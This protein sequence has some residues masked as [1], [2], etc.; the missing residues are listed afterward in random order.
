[1]TFFLSDQPTYRP[2][3]TATPAPAEPA[4]FFDVVGAGFTAEAI[5]TDRFGRRS[6]TKSELVSEMEAALP[7]AFVAR[8]REAEAARRSPGPR[9]P[10]RNFGPGVN[11]VERLLSDVAAAAIEV[12]ERFSKVPQTI[13]QFEA[14]ISR[15]LKADLDE[16]NATLAMG[17]T[18]AGVAE[19][20]GRGGAGMTDETS[21]A[22]LP[23]GGV[24]G[25]ILKTIG[26]EAALGAFGEALIL[27][28]MDVV[29]EDLDIQPPDW[30]AQLGM[31]FLFGGAIGGVG[32]GISRALGYGAGKSAQGTATR[33]AALADAHLHEAGIHRAQQAL[34]VGEPVQ[35]ALALGGGENLAPYIDQLIS[36]ES[37]G[38]ATAKN[39]NSSATGAAQFIEGTWMTMVDRHRPDLKQGRSPAEILALRNDPA[40]SRELATRLWEDNRRALEAR[41]ISPSVGDLYLA[42]F[43]GDGKAARLI[44]ASDDT[45]ISEIMSAAEIAANRNVRWAGKLFEDFTAGDIRRWADAK[46]AGLPD[47]VKSYRA[48]SRRGFTRPDQITTGSGTRI[49]VD[50]AVVDLDS[51]T[52]ASGDL[53]P[54][55][56]TRA[57]S[58]E[59]IADIAA[60][61]DPAR[62]LPSPEA[63]RGAPI[64]GPDGVI[65]SGN[66]RVRALVLASE[67][68][69]DRFDAYVE[70][71]RDQ[72][73]IPE[74]VARP[75][76]IARRTSELTDAERQQFVREANS[77][78]IARMSATEQAAA[79]AA[80]LTRETLDLFDRS[81]GLASADNRA[82][83]RRVLSILPQAERAALVTA[84]GALNADGE[85]R[86]RAAL[87]AKAYD[88]PDLTAKIAETDSPEARVMLRVLTDIAPEWA[89]FR[90]DIEDGLISPEMDVTPQM[91]SAVRLIANARQEAA[92]GDVT[93]R[94]AID[95]ARSQGDL[96]TSD[97]MVD[98]LVDVFHANG[99][100]RA[101]TDVAD[102]LTGYIR[103]ARS[104][105]GTEPSLFGDALSS[106]PEEIINA[107][108]REASTDPTGN[109]LAAALSPADSAVTRNSGVTGSE[110]RRS[111]QAGRTA[112][113]V[114]IASARDED[115]ATGAE[116]DASQLAD[117]EAFDA[118]RADV[119][120]GADFTFTD[121]AGTT[122]SAKE[123]LDDLEADEEFDQVLAVCASGRRAA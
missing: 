48:S 39:E 45:P 111:A 5:E 84:R 25:G 71:I 10:G 114:D 1:M 17:G 22:L 89:A 40:L 79:D 69:P 4:D 20:A 24:G 16:A 101:E 30:R 119:D 26:R 96:L 70:T 92:R 122:F 12:P 113:P 51:L 29:A 43:A 35:E 121:E 28:K 116:T 52:F 85:R 64:V 53:Q 90:A 98:M 8:R 62:L 117:Q 87:F 83:A 61:L 38:R 99:R 67:N 82:F 110:G 41:G 91:L 123:L 75:V 77:S 80:G 112:R 32:A 31:G 115:Y 6:Q 19:F 34:E 23:F 2:P 88:A 59:Q 72:F 36:V 100:A 109:S 11:P 103:E 54:R 104:V 47:P 44:V 73:S 68:T 58:D 93:V 97:P 94:A 55:D 95:D 9:K 106:G 118:L 105:G 3:E 60:S 7:E 108:T 76:L 65:E 18:G 50:Y 102:L 120:A 74:G 13:E 46:M 42:H 33:P 21:L 27:P 78:T 15:R 107:I 49:A 63:D 57:A 14:E 81:A 86:V 56:R 37:G 66:G